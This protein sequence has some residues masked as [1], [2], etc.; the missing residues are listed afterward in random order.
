MDAFRN[1]VDDCG[2]RDMG[3][4]GSVFT[5]RKGT[6]PETYIRERLDRFLADG[7]WCS[8]FPY[9]E[10]RHFPIYHSD[11]AP[12]MVSASNYYERG[13]VERVFK[14][15]ALWLSNE[16]CGKVVQEAWMGSACLQ[17]AQR[18]LNCAESLSAWAAKTFG[19][20][21]KKIKQ[22]KEKLREAQGGFPDAAMFEQSRANELKDGDK[23]TSYFHQE[24]SNRQHINKHD[25]ILEA[26]RGYD[27]SYSW[28]SLWGSKSLLLDGLQWRIGHGCNVK[29]WLDNWLPDNIVPE[30]GVSYDP[31]LRVTDLIDYQ[32]SEWKVDVLQ[33]LFS[34]EICDIIQQLPL[35][36]T[37]PDDA[38]FWWLKKNGEYS[39]KSRYWPSILGVVQCTSAGRNAVSYGKRCG[40]WEVHPPKLRHFVWQACKGGMVVKKELCRRHIAADSFC[41]SCGMGDESVTHALFDCI[42]VQQAWQV[43][44]FGDLLKDAKH[45]SA[46]S[47]IFMWLAGKVDKTELHDLMTIA[48]AIWFCRNKRIHENVSLDLSF[49]IAGF[50]KLVLDCCSY[51]K[52]HGL[53]IADVDYDSFKLVS[54]P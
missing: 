37:L 4:K 52:K 15:E 45:L 12:I 39:V 24:A 35:S 38:H 41:D 30:H 36:C 1:T 21:K 10:V 43:G 11:H 54:Q 14:F 9:Y 17:A 16:D 18:L 19:S 28:R 34:P 29:V 50:S 42:N 8:M 6:N 27:P 48:W 49:T 13:T 23:N 46:F 40:V 7:E 2:M 25:T 44:D 3:F 31:D 26:R 5:W 47:D 22:T 53:E 33:Q 20:V 51:A 32:C